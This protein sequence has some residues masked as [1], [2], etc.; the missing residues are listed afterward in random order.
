MKIATHSGN[1]HADDV[2]AV[3]VLK[4]IYPEA[5]VV[6]TRDQEIIQSADLVVDV[7]GVY[8]PEKG[9]FDHHQEGGGGIR[10]NGI[11]YASFGLVWKEY[12]EKLSGSKEAALIIEEKLVMPVDGPD[13]GVSISKSLYDGVSEYDISDFLQSYQ[14]YS[15]NDESYFYQTFLMVVEIASRLLE[16]EIA[17]AHNKIEAI[18]KVNEALERS[19]DGRIVVLEETLPWKSV[20]IPLPQVLFVVGPRPDGRWG[21]MAVPKSFDGFELKKSLPESWGGK[22]DQELVDI[23]GVQDAV[24]CHRALF[25]A[26]AKTQDGAIELAKRALNQ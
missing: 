7:G 2:F 14:D 15:N 9:R 11:P 12:G 4:L 26:V 22:T 6:R 1:F 25:M 17:K 16:R 21:V 24:F 8:E 5:E 3:A 20:L 18:S 10:P 23:T 13:N 19:E